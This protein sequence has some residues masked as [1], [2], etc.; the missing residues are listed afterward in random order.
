MGGDGCQSAALRLETFPL[1]DVRHIVDQGFRRDRMEIE[2]LAAA[3]YRVEQL[4]RLGCGQHEDHVGGRFLQR[5]QEGIAGGPRQHVGLVEDVY[6]MRS[7]GRGH[8]ADIH[9]NLSDVLNLVVGGGIELDHIQRSALSDSDAGSTLV[10]GF[11]VFAQVGA[12]EGL[13]E[14]SGGRRLPRSARPGE[15]VRMGHLAFEDLARQ[16]PGD[17]VLAHDL[18]EGLRAILPVQR[19]VFHVGD[20]SQ[21]RRHAIRIAAPEVR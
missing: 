17:M 3:S 20:S 8:G 6:T 7:G 21:P 19:L 15:Q 18:G 10:V 16:R 9:T 14:Q 2:P 13:G 11:A 1:C 12:V 5:L 4:V